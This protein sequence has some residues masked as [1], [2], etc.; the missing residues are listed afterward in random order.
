MMLPI[1][2]PRSA[3]TAN[4]RI[5]ELEVMKENAVK[6]VIVVLSGMRKNGIKIPTAFFNYCGKANYLGSCSYYYKQLQLAVIFPFCLIIK[7]H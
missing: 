4:L 3:P 5:V 2:S 1:V 6:I 7:G